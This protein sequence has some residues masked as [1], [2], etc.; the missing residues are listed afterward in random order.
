MTHVTHENSAKMWATARGRAVGNLANNF[1]A[2][3]G[4]ITS[5]AADKGAR[6]MQLCNAFGLPI[7][8]LVDTPGFMVGR[9]AEASGL[10]RHAWRLLIAGAAI[11]VPL[12]AV[13]LRGGYGLGAQAGICRCV[14]SSSCARLSPRAIVWETTRSR[15]S[16]FLAGSDRSSSLGDRR[17]SRSRS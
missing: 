6:F 5:Q 1:Y 8:S 4:A 12:I 17:R 2:L 10:V 15:R 13:I 14:T 9:E 16:V 11:R 3:A 7:V